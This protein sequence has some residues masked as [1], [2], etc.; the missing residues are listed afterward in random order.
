[1]V[2]FT[3]AHTGGRGIITRQPLSEPLLLL[4][5]IQSS[6]K[7]SPLMAKKRGGNGASAAKARK[8]RA[9]RRWSGGPQSIGIL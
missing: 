9:V 7:I 1:M 8:S 2:R 6:H 4:I 5:S 3:E